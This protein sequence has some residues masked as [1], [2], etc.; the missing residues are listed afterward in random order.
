MHSRI[1]Y[2]K[3]NNKRTSTN[4]AHYNKIP[5]E[6]KTFKQLYL[7]EMRDYMIWLKMLQY[8]NFLFFEMKSGSWRYRE[9][10]KCHKIKYN[11]SRFLKVTYFGFPFRPPT[12]RSCNYLTNFC[13]IAIRNSKFQILKQKHGK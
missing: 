7:Q 12:V 11:K 13:S 2:L 10:E 1:K 4:H 9:K 8:H 3:D 6:K 5:I